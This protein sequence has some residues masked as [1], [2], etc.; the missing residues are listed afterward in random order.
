MQIVEDC[1]L[2]QLYNSRKHPNENICIQSPLM[3]FIQNYNWVAFQQKTTLQYQKN[4]VSDQL[5]NK[6]YKKKIN[7]AQEE[8]TEI[9]AKQ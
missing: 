5:K 4:S 8:N 6:H 2:T 7:M 3:S 1:Y 9:N